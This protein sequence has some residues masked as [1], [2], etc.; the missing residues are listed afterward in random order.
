MARVLCNKDGVVHN[1]Y[2]KSN[3]S[4]NRTY[5]MNPH[6]WTV[7]DSLWEDLSVKQEESSVRLRGSVAG[8]SVEDIVNI[9]GTLNK[10]KIP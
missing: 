3:K 7:W 2:R 1:D 10:R 4:I 9:D 8:I 5:S 6:I